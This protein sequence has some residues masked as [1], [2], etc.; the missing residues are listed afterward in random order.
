MPQL[1]NDTYYKTCNNRTKLNYPDTLL[2][3][4]EDDDSD[5][6]PFHFTVFSLYNTLISLFVTKQRP[7]VLI[8]HL[9]L[10]QYIICPLRQ[11]SILHCDDISIF[12]SEN[13]L[14]ILTISFA[15][16]KY[17]IHNHIV[18]HLVKAYQSR[19]ILFIY[20]ILFYFFLCDIA[21]FAVVTKY[22]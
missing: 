18:L 9:P 17:S 20:F 19:I 10:W 4:G 12:I 11:Y 15:I 13:A 3:S 5:K 2:K 22:Q 6:A 21:S 14:T 1:P 7:L 8:Y 16:M